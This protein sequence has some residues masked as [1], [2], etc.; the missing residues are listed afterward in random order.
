MSLS[1]SELTDS[2]HRDSLFSDGMAIAWLLAAAAILVQMLTDGR[3][4]YFRD[5]LYYMALG[6][7][8]AAGYVDLAPLAA[9]VMRF[10]RICFGDSLRAIRFLPALSQA[11]LIVLTGLITRQLGG[12]RFAVLLS[13]LSVLVSPVILVQANRFSMNA[14]EPLFWMGCVYFLL[15]AINQNQPRLLLWCG[16]LLGLGLE[17]KHSTAFFLLSLT[18][19]LLLTTTGRQLLR[20]RW[21]WMAAAIVLLICLPNLVWQYQHNFATWQ[22]LENVRKTHKN[23]ELP[24]LPFLLQQIMMLSPLSALVWLP[25][26]GFLLFQREGKRHRCMGLTF[27]IFFV[28]MMELRAK[29]YYLMPIYPMM[30]AAGGVL[31]EK[32]MEARG[33]FRWLKIALPVLVFIGGTLIAPLVIPILPVEKVAPYM[34]ALGI[35]LKRTEAH[36]GGVLPQ[37]FG[38]EFG[39]PEMVAAVAGVYNAMPPAERATTGI[40]A[41]NYGE[42]GAIDFFGSRYGLPKSISAHQNYYYWGPRQYTGENLILLQGKIEDAQKFCNSVDKGPALDPPYA[43]EEERYT[44]LICHGLKVPLAELWPRLKHWN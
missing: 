10:T 35:K 43:M 3:Y 4:G 42:A 39:W 32:V 2:N 13:C 12:R 17:N 33:G 40:L 28:V 21:F 29:D 27:L 9:F 22:D 25:G 15:R 34:E 37:H 16:V 18:A 19:G 44:I 14:F 11:A 7:H 24:P 41:G 26:L 8:L 31:W 30:F 20:T 23:T 38:D 6:N 1:S 5:E 36:Q